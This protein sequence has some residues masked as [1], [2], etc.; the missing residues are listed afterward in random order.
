MVAWWGRPEFGGSLHGDPGEVVCRFNVLRALNSGSCVD[1][2]G[3]ARRLRQARREIGILPGWF[4]GTRRRSLARKKVWS[5]K[6]RRKEFQPDV[7]PV[8]QDDVDRRIR[9]GRP[10]EIPLIRTE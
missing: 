7:K 3:G 1:R 4:A 5:H 6:S 2:N 8:G 9:I 10:Q